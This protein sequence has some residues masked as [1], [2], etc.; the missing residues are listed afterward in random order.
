MIFNYDCHVVNIIHPRSNDLVWDFTKEKRS[1]FYAFTAYAAGQLN[2][3]WHHGDSHAQSYIKRIFSIPAHYSLFLD[4]RDRFTPQP[5][6]QTQHDRSWKMRQS[7]G[8]VKDPFQQGRTP[9]PSRSYPSYAPQGVVRRARRCRCPV[10]L[11]ALL[12]DGRRLDTRVFTDFY[13]TPN[14]RVKPVAYQ[15][16]K[17]CDRKNSGSKNECNRRMVYL[18]L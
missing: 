10:Y 16:S 17:L 13:V 11:A 4:F 14:R 18:L 12:G 8:K 15:S 6:N 2:V 3:L 1:L 9:V 5:K 7:Q